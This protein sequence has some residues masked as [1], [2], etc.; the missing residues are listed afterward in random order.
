MV[1]V[2]GKHI[3]QVMYLGGFALLLDAESFTR[4]WVDGCMPTKDAD[5]DSCQVGSVLPIFLE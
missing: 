3:N 2:C 4:D 5:T 1:N